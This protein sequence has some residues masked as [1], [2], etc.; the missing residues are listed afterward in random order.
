MLAKH[1]DHELGVDTIIPY[2]VSI[3]DA[4][5]IMTDGKSIEHVG[6]TLDELRLPTASDLA[7]KRDP[8]AVSLLVGR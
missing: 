5:I 1:Y 6:V 4:D 8:Y 7:T 3:T 2:G